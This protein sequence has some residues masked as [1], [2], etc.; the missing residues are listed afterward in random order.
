M[1]KNNAQS[2]ILTTIILLLAIAFAIARTSENDTA[3]T[4]S[5]PTTEEAYVMSREDN[6]LNANAAEGIAESSGETDEETNEAKVGEGIEIPT[7]T[8][9]KQSQILKRLAYTVS[10]NKNTRCP[11]WVAWRLLAT[12]TDGPYNRKGYRFHE[13]LEVPTPRACPEDYKGSPFGM[14]RGH[15]CPAADNKWSDKAMDE[16]H[17]M[18]NICP[19]YGKL[20]GGDWK[21]LEDACRD[22]ANTYDCI[23]IVCGPIFN[24]KHPKAIGHDYVAVPDAFFKVILRLGKHPQA[25]GFIYPN[26]YCNGDMDNYVLS[27]DDVEKA[28]GLDFFSSLDDKIESKVEKASNLH[29][30]K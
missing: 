13:D 14:Q 21:D 7:F 10:Y 18:T 2:P 5:N 4:D 8:I 16:C 11:N 30:W 20:N 28:V 3:T 24:T 26:G 25:L 27:V 29:L 23:Y 1:K 12:R 19:Q 15:M 9:K 22:W 6:G 17:L